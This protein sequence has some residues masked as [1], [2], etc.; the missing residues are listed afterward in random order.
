MWLSFFCHFFERFTETRGEA[1][2]MT[3][4]MMM[5]MMMVVVVVVVVVMIM[6]TSTTMA[7][8]F[9][10]GEMTLFA[11]HSQIKHL[12]NKSLTRV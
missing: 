5:M 10:S 1:V 8:S 9:H 12:R 11:R 3:V 2:M 6:M 4:V 7:M